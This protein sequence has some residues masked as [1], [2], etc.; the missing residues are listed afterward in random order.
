MKVRMRQES[1]QRKVFYFFLLALQAT[2]F[3][4]RYIKGSYIFFCLSSYLLSNKIIDYKYFEDSS[5][6]DSEGD[7]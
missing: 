3:H 4:K 5:L 7:L 6:K 1:S 2:L